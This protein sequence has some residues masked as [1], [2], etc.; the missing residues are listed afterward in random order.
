VQACCEIARDADALFA[1]AAGGNY[2]QII[3]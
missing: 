3:V 1:S 2:H